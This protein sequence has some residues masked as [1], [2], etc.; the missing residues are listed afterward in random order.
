MLLS[1]S[2]SDVRHALLVRL[3]ETTYR[4][5]FRLILPKPS[6]DSPK[7][8]RDRNP[9][10]IVCVD[11]NFQHRRWS[12]VGGDPELL[13]PEALGIFLTEE[14]VAEARKHVEERRAHTRRSGSSRTSTSVPGGALDE[15]RDSYNA[16]QER[17]DDED[18]GKYASKGL[19]AVVCRHDVPL[20]L[21]DIQ[22][23][24]ERQYFA[25]ALIT[26]L[27]SMLPSNATIGVLYDIACQTDRS[28]ALVRSSFLSY[29]PLRLT[30]PNTDSTTSSPKSPPVSS[31]LLL[32]SMRLATNGSAK[33]PSTLGNDWALHLQMERGMNVSG[34]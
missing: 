28:I 30:R 4:R 13:S 10:V 5:E 11:G 16:A 34:R 15:C 1:S 9:D 12:S 27:A 18:D 8:F 20:F 24:G 14:E 3:G 21:C 6:G 26:K 2:A 23:P 32:Y 25:I 33:W 29:H 19:M 17:A 31:S 7:T 22:T